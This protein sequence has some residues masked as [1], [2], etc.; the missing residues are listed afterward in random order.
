LPA[1]TSPLPDSGGITHSTAVQGFDIDAHLAAIIGPAAAV[2]VGLVIALVLIRLFRR[3]HEKKT[4]SIRGISPE[5]ELLKG[6]LLALI[7]AIL[8]TA[9]I[10]SLGLPERPVDIIRHLLSLWIIGAIA[11]LAV[12]IVAM[13]RKLIL[14]HF[15]IESK[16]NLRARQVQT[17]LV[18]MERI[19]IFIIVALAVA[20][21]LMTFHGVRQVGV[22]I[23]ASAGVIGIIIGFAAQKSLGNVIAGLQIAIT[24]PIRLD[25]VVIVE[26]EWGRIE[27]ITLTY[28]VVAI[29]D[30]RRLVVPITYFVEKPFQNWTRISAQLLGTVYIYADYS[31]PVQL[32]REELHRILEASNLWDR[33]V[34]GLVVTNATERTVEMRALMSTADSSSAWNLRCL[35]REK[36]LEFLQSNFPECLPRVRLVLARDEGQGSAPHGPP[37][38]A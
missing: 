26:G 17:Q 24:Q 3:W 32:V 20:A 35:V 29:W 10:R 15:Q 38:P 28:V 31:V 22:S 16:D 8:L 18:V 9:V 4:F 5:L 1:N 2:V 23:L 21:M 36:L 13:I 27:E 6:P 12:R 30:Q 11:W 14:S 37:Q 25:D 34:W 7:P 33:R 19:L